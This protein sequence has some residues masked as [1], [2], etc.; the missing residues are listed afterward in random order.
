M[1]YLHIIIQQDDQ[2]KNTGQYFPW[3][4]IHAEKYLYVSKHEITS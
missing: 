3:N 1:R 4:Y 2:K